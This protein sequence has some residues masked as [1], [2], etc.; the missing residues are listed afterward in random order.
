MHTNVLI[1]W[2]VVMLMQW[3]TGQNSAWMQW[4]RQYHGIPWESCGNGNGK[5]LKHCSN[6]GD[7]YSTHGNTEVMG[8]ISRQ[9]PQVRLHQPP[10]MWLH[11]PPL[12]NCP[13]V[14]LFKLRW[15]AVFS[16]YFLTP[17]FLIFDCNNQ[18]GIHFSLLFKWYAIFI[19]KQKY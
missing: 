3:C 14:C 1:H 6:W 12:I 8:T 11:Q 10:L 5:I 16:V 19:W 15:C 18:E 17:T 13:F 4:D 7:G 9:L 2:R